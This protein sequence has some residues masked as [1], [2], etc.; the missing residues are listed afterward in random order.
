MISLDVKPSNAEPTPST[1]TRKLK[2]WEMEG[3]DVVGSVPELI[4]E[5][6]SNGTE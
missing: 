3:G 1:M 2:P 5:S 6:V 4:T